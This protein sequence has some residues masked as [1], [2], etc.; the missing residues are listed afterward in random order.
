M[1]VCAGLACTARP[2][3]AQ[4]GASQ[5]FSTTTLAAGA[6]AGVRAP[7]LDSLWSDG[8]GGQLRA[9]FPFYRGEV[10]GGLSVHAHAALDADVPDYW[11]AYAFAGWGGALVRLGPVRA[12]ASGRVGLYW[13]RF[14]EASDVRQ[15]S[16]SETEMAFAPALRLHVPLGGGW[17]AFAEGHQLVVLTAVRL[18]MTQLTAGVRHT[19]QTPGWLREVLR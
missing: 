11:A 16:P 6:S 3:A 15:R 17:D 10:E 2:S 5:P 19:L 9:A 18:E 13:M 12:S 14:D 4:P 1:L 7:A 8:T